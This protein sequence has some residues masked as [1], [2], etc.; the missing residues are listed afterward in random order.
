MKKSEWSDHEIEQ[1]LQEMPKVKDHRDPRDIYQSLSLKA[2]KRKAP[3]WI[4]PSVASLAAVLLLFILAPQ[5]WQ[6]ISQDSASKQETNE[7]FDDSNN[8]MAKM[9]PDNSS[10]TG[11]ADHKQEMA[12]MAAPSE[13]AIYE[14][15]IME[16]EVITFSV[17]DQNAQILVPV[18]VLVPKENK[19]WLELYQS[20]SEKL[21][22]VQWG[23][24]DYFPLNATLSMVNEQTLNVDVPADHIYGNGSA[25][26]T[27]FIG[28]LEETM[29]HHENL[30]KITFSTNGNPG[31]MLGNYGERS[32]LMKPETKKRSYYLFNP[33]NQNS[34]FLV[35]GIDV[36]TDI[37]SAFESMRVGN[38]TYGLAPSIPSEFVFEINESSEEELILNISGNEKLTEEPKYIY[39]IEAI[40]LTAKEFGYNSVKFENSPIP[41]I[42]RFNMENEIKVPVA[43]NK[44]ILQ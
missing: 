39:C 11:I 34:P 12:I 23:L 35:P 31:I 17:P 22:E 3:V 15:D 14:E 5:V 8:G 32:E 26:E 41:Q 19:T 30:Q 29:V 4:V 2:K 20:Q 10:N 28:T 21:T 13:T 25:N 7:A 18:S 38:E 27:L 1:L 37:E 24:S 16:Q 9:A 44:V 42:G 6:G 33:N 40:L 36:Y 43:P